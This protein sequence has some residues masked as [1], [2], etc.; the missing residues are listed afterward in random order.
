M[1]V[2]NNGSIQSRLNSM[3]NR[4]T[5]LERAY[6]ELSRLNANARNRQA[7]ENARNHR[8]N[9]NARNRQAN[10]NARNR[11]ANANARNRLR[12]TYL[13][14]SASNDQKAELLAPLRLAGKTIK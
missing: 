10:A 12:S 4:I 9:A 8:A 13:F 6:S 14:R 3:N 7:N 11:Q 1:P 2:S 5:R